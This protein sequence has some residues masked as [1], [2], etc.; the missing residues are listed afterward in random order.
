MEFGLSILSIISVVVGFVVQYY[1][2]INKL[3][4]RLKEVEVKSDL[5]WKIVEKEIP[6]LLHSPHTPK[7][8]LL[9]EKMENNKLDLCEAKELVQHLKEERDEMNPDFGKKLAIILLLARLDQKFGD[10]NIY[11][12]S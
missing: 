9:L 4:E 1:V 5:F 2:V 12:N 8:D 6:R 11:A 10:K 7:L 3:Q